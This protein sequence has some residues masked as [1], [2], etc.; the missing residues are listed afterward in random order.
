MLE[1][2]LMTLNAKEQ[3]QVF[4]LLTLDVFYLCSGKVSAPS[5]P[6]TLHRAC[7]SYHVLQSVN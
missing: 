2:I 4:M 1:S 6:L 7:W 3:G 5:D